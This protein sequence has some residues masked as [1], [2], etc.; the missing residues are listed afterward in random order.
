MEIAL[1]NYDK[2]IEALEELSGG[3]IQNVYSDKALFLLGNTY[4]YALK[5]SEKAS[6]AFQNLLDTFPNS[7]YFDESRQMLNI[8]NKGLKQ[9]I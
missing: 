9:T 1:N 7:L 8:I 2:G 5:N 4:L 3:Q 6:S